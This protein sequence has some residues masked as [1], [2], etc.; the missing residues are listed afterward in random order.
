[1]GI[2]SPLTSSNNNRTNSLFTF[3]DGTLFESQVWTMDWHCV[4]SFQLQE[5]KNIV[6]EIFWKISFEIFLE[7]FSWA[8]LAIWIGIMSSLSHCKNNW[9][10]K[11][12]SAML[13]N[14][15]GHYV[16]SLCWKNN[17]TF[18]ILQCWQSGRGLHPQLTKSKLGRCNILAIN[19][20]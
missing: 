13:A 12:N 19:I 14:L 17:A 5:K 15:D 8:K 4:T 3:T 11:Y 2:V 9:F 6:Q 20:L 1:M 18:S 16:T 10:Q 7:I